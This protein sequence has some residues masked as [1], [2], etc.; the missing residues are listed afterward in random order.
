MKCTFCGKKLDSID[1]E[2]HWCTFC[3]TTFDIKSVQSI[4]N[5][6]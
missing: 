4:L 3:G 2:I 1:C 5:K 6:E